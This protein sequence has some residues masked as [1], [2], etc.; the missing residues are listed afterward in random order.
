MAYKYAPAALVT[1]FNYTGIIWA[2][3]YGWFIWKDWPGSHV[4]TGAAIIIGA[5]VFIAWRE[6]R[7]AQKSRAELERTEIL[8]RS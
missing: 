3:T 7:I 1:M 4:W 5:S 2:T 6:Q 8:L